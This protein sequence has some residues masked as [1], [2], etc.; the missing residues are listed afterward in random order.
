M[1]TK[2]EFT[3]PLDKLELT[4]VGSETN[5]V[6]RLFGVVYI[7]NVRHHVDAFAVKEDAKGNQV[8]ADPAFEGF[9]SDLYAAYEPN[10]AFTPVAFQERQYV[11][12]VSPSAR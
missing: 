1:P 2:N 10:A 5:P 11:V 9:L 7:G 3:L 8:A 12:F 4:P 6:S